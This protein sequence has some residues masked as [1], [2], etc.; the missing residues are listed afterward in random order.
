MAS[1]RHLG[2]K[3]IH[4][5]LCAIPQSLSLG[6]IGALIIANTILLIKYNGRQNPLLYY[7]FIQLRHDWLR[8]VPT[9]MQAV[10]QSEAYAE[11]CGVLGFG[12]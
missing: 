1:L 10:C 12:V 7:N 4:V 5:T 6:T 8:W 2:N 11:A 3:Y 9:C